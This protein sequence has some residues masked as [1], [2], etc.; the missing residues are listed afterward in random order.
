[1]T[2]RR[3]DADWYKKERVREPQIGKTREEME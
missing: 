2:V 1:M 3:A